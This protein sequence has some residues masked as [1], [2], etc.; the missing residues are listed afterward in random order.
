MGEVLKRIAWDVVEERK[1][2]RGG[3]KERKGRGKLRGRGEV[4]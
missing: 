1:R 4:C 3:R 2:S